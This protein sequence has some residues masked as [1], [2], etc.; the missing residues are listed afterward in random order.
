MR[1]IAP[2]WTTGRG[3]SR[4]GIPIIAQGE[5]GAVS[6]QDSTGLGSISASAVQPELLVRS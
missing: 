5:P 1:E 3:P 6:N 2:G 4:T